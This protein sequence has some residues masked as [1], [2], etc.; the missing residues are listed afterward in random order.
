M[1]KLALG[2]NF[3]LVLA[4]A[5]LPALA[6]LQPFSTDG[7]SHFPDGT[8]EQPTL[9]RDCCVAHDAAYWAG[10]DWSSRVLADR[11]LEL[12]VLATDQALVGNIMFLGVRVGGSPFWPTRFR[13][14][15]GWPYG[16][17]YQP[18]TEIELRQVNALWPAQ[19]ARPAYIFRPA[20]VTE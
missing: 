8:N 6:E 18:L 2:F 10:G 9:W 13:W 16:R 12:C 17:G 14:G 20:D 7:C 11:Q 5:A 1:Y 19:V 4:L 15:F 3:A